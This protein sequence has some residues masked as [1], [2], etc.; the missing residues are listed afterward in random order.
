MTQFDEAV[1]D[2]GDTLGGRIA[3]ARDLSGQTAEEISAQVG[4]TLETYAEWENDRAEPRANKLLTLAGILGVSPAWLISGT[5]TGPEAPGIG[6]AVAEM[7]AEITRLR[8]M[9]AQ[10]TNTADALQQRMEALAA[11]ARA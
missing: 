11:I 3:R 5:G 6:S 1:F 10:L 8:D 4:V 7:S 2:D 9:A